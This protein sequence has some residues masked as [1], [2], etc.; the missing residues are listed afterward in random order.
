MTV[1]VVGV[2]P[3]TGSPAALRFGAEEARL[4][5]MPLHAVMA[6][7]PPRP[8]AAPAGRPP[9]GTVSTPAEY[10]AEAE[11]TLTEYVETALGST[12]GVACTVVRG[13]EVNALLTAARDAALLVLGEA[14]AGRLGAAVTRLVAPQVVRKSQCPVVVMPSA[15]TVPA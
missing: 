3:R 15:V 5:D 2:S 12:V 9:A 10:E 6:W 11:L 14:R 8:P 13:S 7:R 1:V 4:R